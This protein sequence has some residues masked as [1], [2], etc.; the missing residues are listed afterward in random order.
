MKVQN[1]LN[2]IGSL[3]TK[4]DGKRIF[5]ELLL[6]AV[7]LVVVSN[8]LGM[9]RMTDFMIFCIAVL[10]YDL[11]YGY[12]G[13]LTIGHMLY[14]GTGTYAAALFMQLVLPNPILA[15]IAGILAGAVLA[16]IIGN[17]VIHT[18]GPVFALVN[19]AFNYMGFFMVAYSW[20]AITGGEDGMRSNTGP[21]GDIFLHRQPTWFIFVLACLL[22]TFLF[23]RLL[24]SSPFGIMVRSLKYNEMRVKFLG[25]D[26]R[27][28]K[29][30]TFTIASAI[31]AFAGTLTTINYGYIAPDYISPLRNADMIFA[32]LIGGTGNL[33]GALLGG[34]L[35]MT[36]RDYIA[37]FL[38]R[39][40]LVLGVILVLAAIKFQT[41][42]VGYLQY[43]YNSQL[44]KY[45]HKHPGGRGDLDA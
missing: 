38:E 27:Y 14:F 15:I 3:S 10:S 42:I 6:I 20:T 37:I 22:V 35:F 34:L 1:A 12:M 41:G 8:F 21:I 43:L 7:V 31:A 19:M 17:F 4:N 2:N 44:R 36:M 16:V 25:Y 26:T 28:Y 30:V 29:L 24:T 9:P 23:L 45:L 32:N 33:Y 11:I 5:L 40:E 39:W 13:Y 18:K